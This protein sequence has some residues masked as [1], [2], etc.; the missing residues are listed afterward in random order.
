MSAMTTSNNR[1]PTVSIHDPEF[2][3]LI[4]VP[5]NAVHH[6]PPA[7]LEI[8]RLVLCRKY[9]PRDQ[10]GS[11]P[12]GDGC[13]FVHVDMSTPELQ[14]QS[15]H[16][17]YAY[18]SLEEVKHERL[19]AG[20]QV[21]VMAPNGRAPSQLVP[22]EMI[23][24]T[25]GALNRNNGK[26]PASHC[27]HY[28]YNRMCNRGER[29]CFLHCVHVDPSAAEFQRAPPR[30]GASCSGAVCKPQPQQHAAP[31]CPAVAPQAHHRPQQPQAHHLPAK[32]ASL[33]MSPESQAE[34]S[35]DLSC[36]L[37]ESP[38]SHDSRSHSPVPSDTSSLVSQAQSAPVQK[39]RTYRH[40]PYSLLEVR[41]QV[42]A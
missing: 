37:S 24:V 2:K 5:L 35:C 17:N 19:P 20:E 28:F 3:N 41:T 29:C 18:R 8:S 38:R 6:L 16:V 7:H 10:A 42:V 15:I 34:S 4:T 11:C 31:C 14:V 1:A 13:K 23:L 9:D 33:F 26:G 25:R 27:A 36:D 40:N 12:M 39:S 22:S 30:A 21:A 32:V